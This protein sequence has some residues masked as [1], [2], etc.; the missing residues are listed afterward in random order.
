VPYELF[1]LCLDHWGRICVRAESFA[2][3]VWPPIGIDPSISEVLSW[4]HSRSWDGA[5]LW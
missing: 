1:R 4:T 3:A 5:S 2:V